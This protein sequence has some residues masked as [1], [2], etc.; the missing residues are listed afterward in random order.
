MHMKPPKLPSIAARPVG[1][2]RIVV[3]GDSHGEAS[4]VRRAIWLAAQLDA[5]QVWSVGDFGIWPGAGGAAFL[6]QCEQAAA[7]H[8]VEV[9]IVPGNH[10]D[11]DQI[12]AALAAPAASG[13]G[14]LRP[15]VLAAAR[16]HVETC[17]GVR[18]LCF[19][20]AA[21]IDGPGGVWGQGR[22]Y[23]Y[24]WWPQERISPEDVERARTAVV[25]AGGQVEIAITHD[26]PLEVRMVPSS[27]FP[28][29]DESRRRISETFSFA[30]PS[31]HVAGHWHR[32]L[33]TTL[34]G[35]RTLVLSA[36]LNPGEVQYAVLDLHA[37]RRVEVHLPQPW[38]VRHSL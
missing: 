15:H 26:V 1:A 22:S 9:R 33:D 18:I 7:S 34:G 8:D 31:L 20:G 4:M 11:Y 10:D 14:R 28:L 24:G 30:R 12:D 36:D 13:W 19:G 27:D 37:D 6:D 29:G 5:R 17:N 25:A 3:I 35:T 23:G 21:S 2:Q 38:D 32:F 16:G